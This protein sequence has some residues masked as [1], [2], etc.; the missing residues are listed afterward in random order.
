MSEFK[1]FYY[2]HQFRNYLIQFMAIFAGMQ[3]SIGSND[4]KGP[5]L[6]S[7]PITNASKDRVV[8]D[9][10]AENT[11]NKPLRLPTMSAQIVNI[12]QAPELRKGVGQHR[13]NTYVP[14]GGLIPDDI[15]VVTQRQPI[16]YRV[17]MELGIFASNQDQ[18][19]Q[20][21]EQILM[22]FDPAIQIQTSDDIFDTAKIS[23]VELIG[24]RLDENVPA[25]VDRRIIQSTLDFS[26]PIYIAVPAD[27]HQRYV[28]DIFLRVGAVSQ[29]SLSNEDMIAELDSQGIQYDQVFSLDDVPIT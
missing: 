7:V 20:I 8:A 24:I 28:Q 5:R 18:H 11:Q 27:V 4:K 22:L 19:M 9:I 23:V 29:S 14:T 16:P 25:G 1:Q 21:M 26:L 10:K 2:N 3:V 12:E 13:R 17:Y 15:T 6:I